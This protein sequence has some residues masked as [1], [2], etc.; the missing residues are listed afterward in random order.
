MKK[1]VSI[2]LSLSAA[3]VLLLS[4]CGGGGGDAT[5]RLKSIGAMGI[6]M[7]VAQFEEV[8]GMDLSSI[9]ITMKADGTFTASMVNFDT[10]EPTTEEGSWERVGEGFELTTSVG[11]V[12]KAELRDGGK[13]L[14]WMPE[15][16]GMNVEMIFEK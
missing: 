16:D 12:I 4:A 7:D 1:I 14:V 2:A 15:I 9:Q 6:T 10:D 3:L 5:Y 11:V 8:V 13:Q